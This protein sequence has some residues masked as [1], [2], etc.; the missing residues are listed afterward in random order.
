MPLIVILKTVKGIRL[1]SS[2]TVLLQTLKQP[3]PIKK[4][5][6]RSPSWLVSSSSMTSR[7]VTL[8]LSTCP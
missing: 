8:S 4:F 1:L 5:W 2:M 3:L 7:K 6:S